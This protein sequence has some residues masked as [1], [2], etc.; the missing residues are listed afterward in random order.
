M[1]ICYASP[2]AVTCQV[3]W[4]TSTTTGEC[5]RVGCGSWVCPACGPR[6]RQQWVA[7]RANISKSYATMKFVTLTL[8]ASAGYEA[9]R[10]MQ[11]GWRRLW[12]WLRRRYGLRAYLWVTE[13]TG[14]GVVHR[15]AVLDMAYVPQRALSQACK[16]FGLGPIVDIRAVKNR[17]RLCSYVL[18]YIT[19]SSRGA[20]HPRYARRVQSS[21]RSVRPSRDGD[22]EYRAVWQFRRGDAS[23]LCSCGVLYSADGPGS[24]CQACAR[25]P[26]PQMTLALPS[27]DC[28]NEKVHQCGQG[29]CHYVDYG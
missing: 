3:G 23:Q 1:S 6:R 10:L 18:K 4:I 28:L 26:P 16:R 27:L 29:V 17:L 21:V 12:Q 14:R 19:K 13:L 24:P 2:I 25:R 8:P 11:A 9:Y 15:H 7:A 20:A 5:L 22:W